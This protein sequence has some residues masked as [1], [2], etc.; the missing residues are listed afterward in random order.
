M[1]VVVVDSVV[2]GRGER[3]G[4]DASWAEVDAGGGEKGAG[5]G[6]WVGVAVGVAHG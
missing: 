4:G 2:F 1:G 3:G 6:A 5:V